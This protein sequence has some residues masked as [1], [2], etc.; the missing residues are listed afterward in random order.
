M[1][2]RSLRHK[3]YVETAGDSTAVI[4]YAPKSATSHDK[5]ESEYLNMK[6]FN[7]ALSLDSSWP[8]L[9]LH[10][11]ID[12]ECSEEKRAQDYPSSKSVRK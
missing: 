6:R 5:K 3:H 11:A 8:D 1:R 12:T 10:R 7:G 9:S 4:K 2:R